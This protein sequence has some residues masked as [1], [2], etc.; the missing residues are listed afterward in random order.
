MQKKGKPRGRG[1]HQAGK[2]AVVEPRS[3]VRVI[4]VSMGE[5]A[6]ADEDPVGEDAEADEDPEAAEVS[7]EGIGTVR[8][9]RVI[10]GEEHSTSLIVTVRL[11]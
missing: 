5:D 4:D 1:V 8:V 10:V 11:S 3:E 9:L 7:D 6:E 2:V